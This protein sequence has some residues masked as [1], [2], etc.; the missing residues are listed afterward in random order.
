VTELQRE[1][2]DLAQGFLFARPLTADMLE[3]FLRNSP[4][5][6]GVVAGPAA[7]ASTSV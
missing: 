2:C 6:A 5:L 1:G 4:G 7:P 3:Q